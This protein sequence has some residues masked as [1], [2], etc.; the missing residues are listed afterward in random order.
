MTLMMNIVIESQK[1]RITKN[2]SIVGDS[3]SYDY[4]VTV[5]YQDPRVASSNNRTTRINSTTGLNV[6]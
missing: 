4:N 1:R 5:Y 6:F 3:I 2:I